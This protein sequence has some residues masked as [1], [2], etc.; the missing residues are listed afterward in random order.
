MFT[1]HLTAAGENIRTTIVKDG[2]LTD[3]PD[4]AKVGGFIEGPP[5]Q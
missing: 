4:Y 3:V 1:D 2:K 5:H